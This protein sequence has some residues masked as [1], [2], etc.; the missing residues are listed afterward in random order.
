MDLFLDLQQ[1]MGIM[2]PV[3][4]VTT[5]IVVELPLCLHFQTR[6]FHAVCAAHKSLQHCTTAV[7]YHDGVAQR[8]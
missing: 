4:E 1:L 3:V 6:V 2:Q 5:F 8:L 7:Q